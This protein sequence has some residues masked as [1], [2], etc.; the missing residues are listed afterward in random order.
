MSGY[1]KVNSTYMSENAWLLNSVLSGDWGFDGVVMSDWFGSHS[2]APT[3]NAGLDLEMPGPTR[4][5][6]DK[7]IAAVAAGDVTADTI[8]TRALNLLR[9]MARTGALEDHREFAEHAIDR[10]EHRALIRRA[11][12]EGAA[13][14]TNDGTLPL[15]GTG[16]FAVIGPNAKTA[17]IMGG[18]SSQLNPHYRISSWD[19]LVAAVGADYLSYAPGCDNGNFQPLL[20]GPLTVQIFA[21]RGPKGASVFGSA[22]CLAGPMPAIFPHGSACVRRG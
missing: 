17:Q 6:G 13:L 1:N 2:T 15:T 11:G 12:A 8:R 20:Q 16:T 3:L 7:A 4:D 14:L 5:R 22:R 10:P 21:G 9:L 18:G 19:G